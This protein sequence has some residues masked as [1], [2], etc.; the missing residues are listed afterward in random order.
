MCGFDV[1]AIRLKIGNTHVG[2]IICY[3]VLIRFA[4]F[5][6]HVVFIHGTDLARL[7][8]RLLRFSGNI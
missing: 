4:N 7:E 8:F 5:S 2:N 6:P 3:A 1:A